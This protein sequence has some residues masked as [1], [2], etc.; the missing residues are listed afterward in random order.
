MQQV[1]AVRRR[2]RYS[3]APT[4]DVGHE[5]VAEGGVVTSTLSVAGIC[6][7]S[8]VPL[9]EAIL[10]PMPGVQSVAV[11]VV[12]R[13]TAVVHDAAVVDAAALVRALNRHHLDAALQLE[14]GAVVVETPSRPKANVLAAIACWLISLG[15][16]PR[17]G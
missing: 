17:R 8:E 7:P 6:C 15:L 5:D 1:I 10:G 4:T 11:N 9:I 16:Q 13:T 2:Q 14:R 3:R 12:G